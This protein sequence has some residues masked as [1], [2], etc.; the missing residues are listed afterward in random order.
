MI[1]E[2]TERSLREERA[3]NEHGTRAATSSQTADA[4]T[5]GSRRVLAGGG[6][7]CRGPDES[8]HRLP[9][10][11]RGSHARRSRPP[12]WQTWTP[13]QSASPRPPLAGVAVPGHLA[14]CKQPIAKRTTRAAR[15][16]DQQGLRHSLFLLIKTETGS[17]DLCSK[18]GS[19]PFWTIDAARLGSIQMVECGA[20]GYR[21][22]TQSGCQAL[23]RCC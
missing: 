5:H 16:A 22:S 21:V 19:E 7:N 4:S 1:Q 8:G 14:G 6:N 10:E 3:W 2:G 12:R 9:L 20:E 11:A 23:S 13:R 15:S 17:R 18:T